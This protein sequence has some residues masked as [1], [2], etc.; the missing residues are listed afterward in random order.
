MEVVPVVVSVLETVT[1]T[2]GIFE[3]DWNSDTGRSTA[4]KTALFGT[5]RILRSVLDT[6][7]T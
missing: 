2:K 7:E 5:A 3:K 4:K 1:K 6:K